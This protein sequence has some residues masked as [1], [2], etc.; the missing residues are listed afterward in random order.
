MRAAAT[1]NWRARPKRSQIE[2]P[3]PGVLGKA[4]AL[5]QTAHRMFYARQ[6]HD[7]STGY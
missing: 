5:Y 3:R 6:Y 1:R 7:L 4:V 2:T